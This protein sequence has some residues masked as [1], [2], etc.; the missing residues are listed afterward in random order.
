MRQY[1]KINLMKFMTNRNEAGFGKTVSFLKKI[2][3][4]KIQKIASERLYAG[5]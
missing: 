4:D 2:V 5:K 1:P 3:T